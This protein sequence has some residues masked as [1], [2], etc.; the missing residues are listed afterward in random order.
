MNCSANWQTTPTPVSGQCNST[1]N[2]AV[3]P[4]GV[5]AWTDFVNNGSACTS[6]TPVQGNGWAPAS[7]PWS[8]SCAGSNG[9]STASCSARV[10]DEKINGTCNPDWNNHT[11]PVGTYRWSDFVNNGSACT[12]GTPVQGNGWAPSMGPWTWSCAG[13]NGGTSESCHTD[14]TVPE[15]P[16]CSTTVRGPQ[17]SALT[18]GSCAV[19]TVANFQETTA[20]NGT[21]TYT[22]SCY[23]P[24]ICPGPGE[25]AFSPQPEYCVSP[26]CSAS[27]TPTPVE[28]VCKAGW[29]GG[30]APAGVY[31]WTDFVRNGTACESGEPVKGTGWAPASGPWTWSCA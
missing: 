20:A 8:W 12:S 11:A 30:S 19:G 4:A 22:W 16:S 14:Q 31:E 2:N 21:I 7:G 18:A 29:N 25:A 1:W 27:Y 13:V 6:G 26:S 24:N 5:F 3:I 10:K 17:T 15:N 9:G 28:G 23:H